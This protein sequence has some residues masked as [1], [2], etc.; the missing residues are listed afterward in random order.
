ML[1]W[2]IKT[3]A[4]PHNPWP[5]CPLGFK[6]QAH[7]PWHKA[8][9]EAALPLQ[10]FIDTLAKAIMHRAEAAGRDVGLVSTA[11]E[12]KIIDA[13]ESLED[14]RLVPVN[15]TDLKAM[16]EKL[17]AWIEFPEMNKDIFLVLHQAQEWFR[18]LTG[19]DPSQFGG[20]Q[21]PTERSAKASQMRE[22]GIARRPDDY[23][24]C[25][26]AWMSDMAS[27]EAVAARLLVEPETVAPL[28]GE[29]GPDG[30]IPEAQGQ[31]IYGT[32]TKWW[33][34]HIHTDDPAI[35]TA[36]FD[37][38]VEAGTGR[39]RNK[40][41]QQQNAQQLYTMMGQQLYAF[42]ETPFGSYEPY[43]RLVELVGEAYDMPTGPLLDSFKQAIFQ[44]QQAMQMQQQQQAA[45]GGGGGVNPDELGPGGTRNPGGGVLDRRWQAAAGGPRN[46]ALP[47]PPATTG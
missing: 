24:D 47:P 13:M 39:R 26:E 37:Y 43:M 4:N 31:P 41:L 27:A 30:K 46:V 32:L 25:V 14:L 29:V 17:I 8:I 1:E 15:E 6:P 38:Q 10:K 21:K 16:K 22:S 42:G 11:L 36:E 7:T 5:C 35:A 40:Q 9:L 34:E 33:I 23:A 28:F 12:E 2:P 3:Y 18:E 44:A 45:P 20:I 19:M